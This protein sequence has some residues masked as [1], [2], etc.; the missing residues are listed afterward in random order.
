M[1]AGSRTDEENGGQVF[2]ESENGNIKRLFV[3]N[4]KLTGFVLVGNVERTGIYTSLIRSQTPLSSIN[5][6]FLRKN[7][8]LFS[9]ST[10]YRR[11]NLGSVV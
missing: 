4:D 9:F 5:F 11:K 8:N 10:N 1:T 2:D 6:D 3:K 7:P